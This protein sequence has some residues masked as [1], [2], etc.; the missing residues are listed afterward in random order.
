MPLN[1][2]IKVAYGSIPKDCGTFTFY[3]SLQKGLRSL[4]V[5]LYCVSVGCHEA[6]GW[7]DSFADDSC[8][9]LA[10]D[11]RDPKAQAQAFVT[12]VEREQIDLVMPIN[13][14]AMLAAL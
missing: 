4:G 11:E 13:S 8:V 2:S 10:A 1:R 12:W 3:R 14:V 7:N 5:Q 9:R 6:A